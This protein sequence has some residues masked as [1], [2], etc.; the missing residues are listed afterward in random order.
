MRNVNLCACALTIGS[1]KLLQVV[2]NWLFSRKQWESS[3][4]LLAF[5]VRY[6]FNGDPYFQNYFA[7]KTQ[8]WKP[9]SELKIQRFWEA[10]GLL[11]RLPHKNETT[12]GSGY[13]IEAEWSLKTLTAT[14]F[15]LRRWKSNLNWSWM[16]SFEGKFGVGRHQNCDHWFQ[17]SL[18]TVVSRNPYAFQQFLSSNWAG[19]KIAPIFFQT[20]YNGKRSKS[21]YKRKT[22]FNIKIPNLVNPGTLLNSDLD[23]CAVRG[24]VW[25]HTPW[26]AQN[27]QF[28]RGV[29]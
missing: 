1:W 2:S 6:Y 18:I 26:D 9:V 16:R 24:T 23:S 27:S 15:I 12:T 5:D 3:S 19:N 17:N 25:R 21:E 11:S 4:R 29:Y 8:Q 28:D 13:R 10:Y 7:T 20:S 14:F 22:F